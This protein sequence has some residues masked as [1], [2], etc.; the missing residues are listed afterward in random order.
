MKIHLLPL[1]LLTSM[2][3]NAQQKKGLQTIIQLDLNATPF[4]TFRQAIEQQ[5]HI[6][7][8]YIPEHFD[9]LKIT[10]KGTMKIKEALD[11]IY[12]GFKFYYA[13]D[14][15]DHLYLTRDQELSMQLGY[16]TLTHNRFTTHPV[17][18][19]RPANAKKAQ[20]PAVKAQVAPTHSAIL[21]F[22]EN[23]VFTI[24][25]NQSTQGYATVTGYVRHR[26]TGEGIGHASIA[27]SDM[28]T[29]TMTDAYGYYTITL[30]KGRHTL[31]IT[32]IGLADAR[33]Q[34]DI[35]GAG[36]LNIQ[37]HD[38]VTSLKGVTIA[39]SK[40][41]NILDPE[42]GVAKI[43][44]RALKQVPA[45]M[46]EADIL[47]VL[48]TLPGVTSAGEGSTG[49]N[50][51]GGNVDQN[52]VLLDGATIY[53]PSHFFGFFSGFNADLVKDAELYKSSIPVKYGSRLSSVLEVLTR[54][55]NRNKFSGSGGIGPLS[56]HLSLEGPMG[57]KTSFL[58]GARSTYSDWTLQLL[59]DQYKNSRA[60]F[61]DANLKITS[62]LN[63]HNSLFV[64]GY[65]S[66]DRFRLDGDTLY[67]YG[68]LNGI[69]KWKH[70]FNPH[71]YGSMDVGIDHYNFDMSSR[72]N[73]INAYTFKFD[74]SQYHFNTNLIYTPNNAHKIEA[75]ISMV[76]Y[77][78]HPG[79][80]QPLDSGITTPITLSPE[81]ALESA[82]YISDQ[83]TVSPKLT[84][85][86][87]LRYSL[88]NYLG[89]RDVYGYA[90]NLEREVTTITDTTHY[91]A[92]KLIKTYH[93]PEPR[94]S[95]RYSLSENS[96]LKA[97]Y[98][99][100]R[101]YI[102]ML[103]NTTVVTPTDIWKLS[104]PY[105]KPTVADQVSLGIYHNFKD[106]VIETSIEVY[107]KWI[108]HALSYKNDATLLLNP[109]IETDVANADSK[110]YG[111][112]FLVKKTAGKLNGWLSYTYS[113]VFLRMNDPLVSEP[114]NGGAYYPAEYDKPHVV[115][116]IA[117]YRVSHR[118][119]LSLTSIYTT[120]RPITLPVAR[121]YM[122]G[123]YRVYYEDRNQYRI[124]DYFRTDFSIN[125]EGNHKIR[126]LAH[127][128]WT[129][130][131]YNMF[132][133]K[134]AYSVYFTSEEG[135]VNGYKLSIFGT[136][137]PFVTYNFKF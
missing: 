63:D 11:T 21:D 75:G 79:S 94:I 24:G 6:T 55:G 113:R 131:V 43:D 62:D 15:K 64:A 78:L 129:L 2:T 5:A 89:P 133:R 49:L 58:V 22:D 8:Y 68:N 67:R 102:H 50:V 87:G 91:A 28:Q 123:S 39:S 7:C 32:C 23:K 27:I 47:R 80:K 26:N 103:S 97:A 109:H 20:H 69:V 17:A 61:Y 4:S 29:K 116:L 42:M 45:L 107:Y 37:L 135:K 59:P 34:I 84:V 132:A 60:G 52:L 108:Q 13:C 41:H 122:S 85:E 128:S 65:I 19:P 98:N 115:N 54:E 30:P 136:A 125:I 51:R 110:A 90:P 130:G 76:Y 99:R 92:G 112:E 48:Q 86:V 127:S 77:K 57:S 72:D 134:N 9:T 104:D 53:N 81:Q 93:G 14:D 124:P 95:A 119:S 82:L 71:L 31:M 56:G 121:Y 18:L 36:Q 137:I 88:F 96:S 46:G 101:Q 73:K 114:V 33:R 117:N 111:V 12:A 44:I 105:I 100:T 10:L 16:P 70:I 40:S 120:G 66:G 3:L 126:K 83:Y 118:F 74:V 35:R 38:Y 25:S 106:N 1:L